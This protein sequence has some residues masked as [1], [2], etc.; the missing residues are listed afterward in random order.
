[1]TP[2]TDA[3]ANL[4]DIHLPDP[5]SAWPPAPAWWLLAALAVAACAALVWWLRARRRS[6]RRAAFR[7]LD[8]L[9]LAYREAPDLPRL[10]RELSSL[11]RRFALTRFPRQEV[12][13]LHGARWLEF[14]EQSGRKGFPRDVAEAL[15]S[16]LY[17]PHEPGGAEGSPA[18]DAGPRW[19]GA[20]RRWIGATP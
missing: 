13:A 3:L 1:M 6:A 11:L 8:R 16:A 9:A 17:R 14:L 2:P 15:E 18:E 4:R 20:V 10:A 5:V 7:E 19:L 12:A